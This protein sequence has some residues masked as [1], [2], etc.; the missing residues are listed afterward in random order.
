MKRSGN[1]LQGLYTIGVTALF[2]AG[3]FLLVVI[4]ARI[5]R[6]TLTVR[7]QNNSAR[8]QLSTVRTMLREADSSGAVVLDTYNGARLLRIADGDTGYG[9]LIYAAD[10]QL[11][12]EYTD[13]AAQPDPQLAEVIAQTDTFDVSLQQNILTVT[14]DAGTVSVCLRSEGGAAV[15]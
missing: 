14:M 7:E 11:L 3:F 9:L 10:G 13:I 15:E 1:S 12:Q 8:A 4:G 6:D 5:Y 2:L